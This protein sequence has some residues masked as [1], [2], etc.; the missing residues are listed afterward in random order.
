MQFLPW[1]SNR[2][3]LSFCLGYYEKVDQ[4]Q[5]LV[6]PLLKFWHRPRAPSHMCTKM[7]YFWLSCQLLKITSWSPTS[8]ACHS[9]VLKSQD[10]GNGVPG[11]WMA[12]SFTFLPVFTLLGLMAGSFLFSSRVEDNIFFCTRYQPLCWPNSHIGRCE[13]PQFW[14]E[15]YFWQENNFDWGASQVALV[16]KNP[17]A[18]AG[19]TRYSGV[20]AVLGRFPGGGYG[21]PLQYSCWRIPRTEEPG[22]LQSIGSQGVRHYWSDLT[23]THAI[24]IELK[25]HILARQIISIFFDFMKALL[26]TA[27]LTISKNISVLAAFCAISMRWS[28][29]FLPPHIS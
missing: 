2:W 1:W 4:I 12:L 19:G 27:F 15:M 3:L 29:Y 23:H 17:P 5:S 26:E 21:N 28:L 25:I 16:V 6:K 9:Y 7:R 8:L 22:R 14:K 24:L 11:V 10:H 18:N 20:V 13:E